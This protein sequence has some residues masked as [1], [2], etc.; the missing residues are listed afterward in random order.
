[1]ELKEVSYRVPVK[2]KRQPNGEVEIEFNEEMKTEVSRSS[3]GSI[4][5]GEI[6]NKSMEFADFNEKQKSVIKNTMLNSES[7]RET[8]VIF[9]YL[10]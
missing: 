9:K 10:E 7:E 5:S 2:L 1:M 3:L 8:H 4:S 6:P